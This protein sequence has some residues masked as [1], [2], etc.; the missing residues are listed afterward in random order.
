MGTIE[1]SIDFDRDLTIQTVSGEI[2]AG[3]LAFVI[4]TYPGPAIARRAFSINGLHGEASV[5]I[6]TCLYRSHSRSRLVAAQ[7]NETS[8]LS[9]TLRCAFPIR[10]NPS[11]PLFPCSPRSGAGRRSRPASSFRVGA[12]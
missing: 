12:C 1:T 9:G 6:D 8:A 3:D 4:R 5:E 10:G 2:S 11:G 7:I